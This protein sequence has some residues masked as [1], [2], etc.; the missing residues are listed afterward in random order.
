[1]NRLRGIE[2]ADRG[3][4]LMDAAPVGFT[5]DGRGVTDP[6][7]FRSHEVGATVFAAL[8]LAEVVETWG[9]VARELEFTALTL[10]A[11]P[12]ALAIALTQSQALLPP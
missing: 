10:T 7:G 3:W 6:V 1:M 11:A 12:L 8:V 2:G 9:L 4:V 5:I